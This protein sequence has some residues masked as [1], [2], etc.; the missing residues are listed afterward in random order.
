MLVVL[1]YS[2]EHQRSLSVDAGS[3]P[4]NWIAG[5]DRSELYDVDDAVSFQMLEDELFGRPPAVGVVGAE[6][7][8]TRQFLRERK[9]AVAV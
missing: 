2:L 7:P 1:G 3:R 4:R 5:H 8:A 9:A 6:A